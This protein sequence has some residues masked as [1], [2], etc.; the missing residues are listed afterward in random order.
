VNVSS[1]STKDKP[2]L[3][4]HFE[5][6]EFLDAVGTIAAGAKVYS[7]GVQYADQVEFWKWLTTN[8]VKEPTVGDLKLKLDSAEAVREWVLARLSEDKGKYVQQMLQNRGAEFDFVRAMQN[9]PLEFLSGQTWRMATGQEDARQGIDAV[10]T[11]LFSGDQE[12]HQIKA[13]LSDTFEKVRLDKYMG[14]DRRVDVVDV[15]EKI[16]DWRNSE[17]GRAAV[18]SRGD[19][20]PDVRKAFSDEEIR[21]HADERMKQAAQ[22]QASP[23]YTLE[24]IAGEIGSGMMVGAVV[25]IGISAFANYRAYQGRQISGSEF[26]NRLMLDSAQGATMGGAMAAVNIP[27]QIAAHA[28]G[29]GAPVTIPVMIVVGAGLR[30]VIAAAFGKGEYEKIVGHMTYTTDL[31]MGLARFAG[32]SHRCYVMQESFVREVAQLGARSVVLTELSRKADSAV[33]EMLEDF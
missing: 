28:I 15:N 29:V 14:G 3:G 30:K 20:H 31:T 26:A 5:V 13:G 17:Q 12:T 33:D 10:R 21:Q 22:G 1:D 19:D 32:L 8:V 4:H 16:H 23:T 7:D 18:Q 25:G 9:D 6:E 2:R 11:N 27:V 24:G